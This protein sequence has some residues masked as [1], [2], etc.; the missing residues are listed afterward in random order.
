[1]I[2]IIL[3]YEKYS[4]IFKKKSNNNRFLK[5]NKHREVIVRNA[6]HILIHFNSFDIPEISSSLIKDDVHWIRSIAE[7]SKKRQTLSLF[8]IRI[9]SK[10]STGQSRQKGQRDRH[11]GNGTFH[12]FSRAID[13]FYN[14]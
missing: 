1:M 10:I 7:L 8:P 2:L 6:L 13:R 5:I 4:S 14:T 11:S 3:S 12:E 9:W